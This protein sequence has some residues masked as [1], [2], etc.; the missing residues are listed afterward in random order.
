[1][2]GTDGTG[3][4]LNEPVSQDPPPP[5]P[6]PAKRP[7]PWVVITLAI[8]NIGVFAWELSAGASATT[9]TAQWM[10]EH[11][12]NF[13]PLTLDG[14]QWRLFT[15]MFLHFGVLHLVMNMVGL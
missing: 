14:Q 5:Q 2:N 6:Q 11:G 7:L 13:G 10:L 12:G 1:M 3:G 15:S 8:A 4:C 9:P